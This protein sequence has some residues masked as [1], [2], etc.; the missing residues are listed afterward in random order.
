MATTQ[1]GASVAWSYELKVN[2]GT[3]DLNQQVPAKPSGTYSF[4]ISSKG[5][6]LLTVLLQVKVKILLGLRLY[7]V[8]QV[9]FM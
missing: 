9:G 6:R 7:W 5:I 1:A 2:N 4:T 3:Q 8:L